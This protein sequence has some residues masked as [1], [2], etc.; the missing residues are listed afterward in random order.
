MTPPRRGTVAGVLLAA[1]GGSR[2]D[3]STHKLLAEIAGRPV[4]AHA[5]DALLRA[6]L[7]ETVVVTGAASISHLVPDGVTVVHNPSWADGQ[8]TSLQA[9]VRHCRDRGHDAMVVGLADQPGIAPSTWRALAEVEA[10][11]AV[12]TYGGRRGN[13]V[14]LGRRV[15][16][17]LPTAGDE[18][19]RS[20]LLASPDLV[21]PVACEGR[22]DDIDT[23]EDLD[24]WS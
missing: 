9:A 3:G 12:A 22:S 23:M 24:R 18:G 20:L 7:D 21:T 13:P 14:R 5:L 15:W 2:F 6:G 8:A 19:A 10:D 4:V 17:E 16:D 1:G 11:L